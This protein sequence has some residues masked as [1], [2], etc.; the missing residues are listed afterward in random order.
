MSTAIRWLSPSAGLVAAPMDRLFEQLL[1]YRAGSRENGTP[2]NVLP[3]DIVETEDAYQLQASVAGVPEDGVEVTSDHG[4]LRLE[5]KT[6]PFDG[7]GKFIRQER[8][9]GNWS[10][11][12]ELPKGVDPENIKAD[13][14]NGLLTVVIPK[15]AKTEPRRIAV[16]AGD[17]AL[18]S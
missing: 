12:L 8:P 5:L 2:S 7:Q 9:V 6:E 13:F 15:A 4:M 14:A 16:G 18:E 10:R 3:V 17:R 11:Q 1:G